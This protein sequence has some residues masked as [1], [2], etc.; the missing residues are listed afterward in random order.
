MCK[1]NQERAHN[2]REQKQVQTYVRM[3]LCLCVEN[4]KNIGKAAVVR[5]RLA[6]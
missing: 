6:Q 1:K 5:I 4:A 3:Y 2:E